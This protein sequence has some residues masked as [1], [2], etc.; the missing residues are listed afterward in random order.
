MYQVGGGV[1]LLLIGVS[2]ML[3]WIFDRIVARLGGG[4]LS[5]QLALRRLQLSG[6][7]AVRAVNAVAVAAAGTIALQML[8]AAAQHNY[9]T[10]TDQDV[11][12]VQAAILTQAT[13]DSHAR[14][15]VDID[16]TVRATPIVTGTYTLRTDA[17]GLGD[18]DDTTFAVI[19]ADCDTL[20]LLADLTSCA[21]GDVFGLGS[22]SPATPD[23]TPPALA[24][25]A[26]KQITIG[27]DN[28]VWT[29]PG[30]VKEA[31]VRRD[32]SGQEYAGLLVTPSR[33]PAAQPY[34]RFMTFVRYNTAA[35][36]ADEQIRNAGARIDPVVD[37]SILRTTRT[38]T[39]FASIQRG[40]Y[41]GA[42]VVLLLVGLSLLVATIEQLRDRRRI[43]AALVA[44]GTRRG[45]MGLSILWQTA[46]PVVLGLLVAA[47]LGVA[48][49]AVLLKIVSV[50]VRL[51]WASIG[52]V[53]G[54][55]AGVV[56]LVAAASLPP[57]FR[58]M[59]P[60]GLRFE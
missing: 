46:V 54:I 6:D 25:L 37:V 2:T 30:P 27:E 31:T 3:P 22:I 8:F 35:P 10:G 26:G 21:D 52:A 16:A 47:T 57:L 11:T 43:L 33:A 45:T 59:R 7:S 48:V 17:G 36:D 9:I 55:A 32:P 18:A 50:P 56:L 23:G 40:L 4:S 24:S 42:A 29:V 28:A 15:A 49:G 51:D 39:T 41:A 5:W 53:S 34:E 12:R 13:A 14:T 60:E 1:I 19:V 44:F 20:R 38:D 58:L